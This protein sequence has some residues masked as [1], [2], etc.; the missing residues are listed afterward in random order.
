[1]SQ[2]EGAV[3][4]QGPALPASPSPKTLPSIVAFSVIAAA[5][6]V[7]FLVGTS[8]GKHYFWNRYDTTPRVDR[9]LAAAMEKVQQDPNN[10]DNQVAL[11]W[12]YYRKG[13][14]N[15]ALARYSKAIELNDKHY[16]AQFNLGLT[17]MKIEKWDRA[18]SAFERAVSIVPK[19]Y[20]AHWQLGLAHTK[21]GKMEEA[22]QELETALRLR[23]G[24][25]EILMDL[26]KVYE[27][28]GKLDE[29]Q[30]RYQAASD[31]DPQYQPA[32][33]ALER[34]KA[35]KKPA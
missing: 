13:D 5:A 23:P 8:I 33:D 6:V 28:M 16:T 32:R 11:G 21:Q 34:V 22:A 26:G 31:F 35:A 1:M 25:V 24:E 4:A 3:P 2:P 14:Y 18:V 9:D 15:Q 27:G 7:F 10:A 29:A 12:A 17:Y 20:Q 30:E 19:S